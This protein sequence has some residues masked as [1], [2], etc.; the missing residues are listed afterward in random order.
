MILFSG[1][2]FEQTMF[3]IIGHSV[4]F[5]LFIYKH[6][7]RLMGACLFWS[8][9]GVSHDDDLVTCAYTSC[10]CSVQADHTASTFSAY[11][12]CLEPTAV[13]YSTI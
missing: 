1:H 4:D 7:C 11:G 13:V 6:N 10:C 2:V 5:V 3:L 8:Y 12:V 9:L